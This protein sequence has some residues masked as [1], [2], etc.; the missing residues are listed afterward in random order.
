MTDSNPLILPNL[1][2]DNYSPL[3]DRME[4]ECGDRTN[5]IWLLVNPKYSSVRHDIW[6]PILEEIQDKVY[7][8]LHTRIDTKNIF[9]KNT[10]SDIGI[11]SNPSNRWA[12]KV[13]EADEIKQ[14]RDIILEHQPKIIITF[15]I[16]TCELVRHIFEI[17]PEKGPRYWNTTNLEDEFERSI[18]NF[19][20][21]KT[22]RIPLPRRVMKSDKALEDCDFSIWE[23]INNYF[24]DIGAKIADKFIEHKDSFK[25]WIE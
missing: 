12:T 4:K 20:I 22:N 15:G 19:D 5:P 6:T 21:N 13:A 14:L 11:V 16:L 9:I 18:A 10:I 2:I 23:D 3:V 25:I 1:V 17:S 8:K 24:R 7:R